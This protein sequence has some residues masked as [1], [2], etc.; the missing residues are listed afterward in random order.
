MIKYVH[1]ARIAFFDHIRNRVRLV[2][3]FMVFTVLA[4]VMIAMWKM[5][6]LSGH[7]AAGVTLTDMSWYNGIVQMMFFFRRV[8]LW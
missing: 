5:I 2:T 4:W 3:R 6:Y 1:F 7:G 8:C